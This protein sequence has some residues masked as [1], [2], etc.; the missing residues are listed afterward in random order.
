[1]KKFDSGEIKFTLV[2]HGFQCDVEIYEEGKKKPFIKTSVCRDFGDDV[3]LGAILYLMG[4]AESKRTFEWLAT[5]NMPT[6][7]KRKGW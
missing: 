3:G 2:P 7:K 6:K 4:L 5:K 1:M